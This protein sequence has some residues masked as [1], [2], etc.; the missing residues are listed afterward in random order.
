MADEIHEYTIRI[1]G[2][3]SNELL[4]RRYYLTKEVK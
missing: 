1:A 3:E 4:S 2:G